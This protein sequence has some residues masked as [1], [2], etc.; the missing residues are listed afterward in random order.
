M[1]RIMLGRQ[2]ETLGTAPQK[3]ACRRVVADT[4]YP[5]CF[6]LGEKGAGVSPAISAAKH[7]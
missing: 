4:A 6:K 5:A 1:R 7:R 2:G 3:G